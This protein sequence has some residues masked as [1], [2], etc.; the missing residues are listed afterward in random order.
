LFQDLNDFS[1][2][3][4]TLVLDLSYVHFRADFDSAGICFTNLQPDN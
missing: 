4:R 1:L 2:T 3:F